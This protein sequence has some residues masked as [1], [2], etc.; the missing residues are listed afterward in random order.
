MRAGLIAVIE[1]QY[2]RER[3]P[4]IDNFCDIA[5]SM[6]WEW[7]MEDIDNNSVARQL[8]ELYN[9]ALSRASIWTG[10]F[11]RHMSVSSGRIYVT[12]LYYA[13]SQSVQLHL[14]ADIK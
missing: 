11:D 13:K 8:D 5:E 2:W 1:T 7:A 12:I 6:N 4:F 14:T 3:G 10:E 9:I